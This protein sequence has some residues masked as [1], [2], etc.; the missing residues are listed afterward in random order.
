MWFINAESHKRV[1]KIHPHHTCSLPPPHPSP[2][3]PLGSQAGSGIPGA[4][5]QQSK[6]V[7][8]PEPL[9]EALSPEDYLARNLLASNND[10]DCLGFSAVH[11]LVPPGGGHRHCFFL[12]LLFKTFPT[13]Q[14]RRLLLSCLQVQESQ[15]I[16]VHKNQ[17]SNGLTK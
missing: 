6:C 16:H 8:T 1:F 7:L 3:E 15:K 14:T 11:T 5:C 9:I 2:C 12:L 13:H 10:V 17:S 4:M